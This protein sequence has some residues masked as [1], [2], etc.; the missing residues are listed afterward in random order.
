MSLQWTLI[1]MPP[2]VLIMQVSTAGFSDIKL[3]SYLMIAGVS[4]FLRLHV[5]IL[6]PT[7]LPWL[8]DQQHL[9]RISSILIGFSQSKIICLSLCP[10][11][12]IYRFLLR[13]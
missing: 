13:S 5:F 11:K 12:N 4:T 10:H 3:G 6:L 7:L 9:S 2:L 8:P 1:L